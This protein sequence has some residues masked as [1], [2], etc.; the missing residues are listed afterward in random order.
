[1]GFIL[2]YI[3]AIWLPIM[4]FVVNKDHR[5]TAI[6][7]VI[8]CMVLLRMQVELMLSIGYPSGILTFTSMSVFQR[9]VLVYTVFYIIYL[10]LLHFSAKNDKSI[11]LASSIGV[12]FMVFFVSS[13][14]MVL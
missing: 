6:M 9:G 12:F 7:Y 8:G 1:M 4:W 3:D 5:R 14:V 2:Q 13:V 11:V 10:L